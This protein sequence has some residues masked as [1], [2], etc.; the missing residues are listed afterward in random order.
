[1]KTTHYVTTV[2]IFFFFSLCSESYAQ[3]IAQG[4]AH[5]L[6][7]CSDETVMAWGSNGHG[8]LGDGSTGVNSSFPVS[9]ILLNDVTDISGGNFFT[10]ALKSDG[11]V[12]AYGSNA[13]GSLGDNTNTDRFSPV[14]VLGEG[15]MGYLNDIVAISSSLGLGHSLALKSDGTVWAWGSNNF[16]QLGDNKVAGGHTP[17]QVHGEDNIGFLTNIIQVVAAGEFSLA[18]K[19]DGTVWAWGI[20]ANGNLGNGSAS[21]EI[22][23]PVQVTGLTNII[24]I[25]GG[26]DHA[27]AIKDDGTVWA[28]GSDVY[29]ELGNNTTD[30][31]YFDEPVEALGITN[32]VDIAG[33]QHHTLILTDDGKVWCMGNNMYGQ[34]GD[35]TNENRLVPTLVTGLDNV[36][37]IDGGGS[38]SMALC[39]DGTLWTWG[40]N[41]FGE[42]GNGTTVNSWSPVEVTGICAMATSLPSEVSHENMKTIYPNPTTGIININCDANSSAAL[43]VY[44]ISG[45]KVISVS[46][47]DYNTTIDLAKLQK[48]TYIVKT[49]LAD[50]I[51]SELVVLQ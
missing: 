47:A 10:T 17:V 44:N 37:A 28:W 31:F 14:Q 20:N 12:W 29:G 46:L 4:S 16:G 42:L 25:A 11:T 21:Y 24:K 26:T 23:V 15:G 6:S 27:M 49:I 18:L 41:G 35:G 45:R 34:L 19:D 48:G 51:I 7:I 40:Y 30:Y 33:G 38:S 50:H 13:T 9:T 5:T 32:A 1:M 8:Q 43:E 22:D 39:S 3:Q 36:V 2:I